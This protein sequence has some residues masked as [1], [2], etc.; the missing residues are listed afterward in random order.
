MEALNNNLYIGANSPRAFFVHLMLPHSPVLYDRHGYVGKPTSYHKNSEYAVTLMQEF[1]EKLKELSVYDHSA[2]FFLSD[3]GWGDPKGKYQLSEGNRF[4]SLLLIKG[5]HRK[6]E[7]ILSNKVVTVPEFRSVIEKISIN[8]GNPTNVGV[9]YPLTV[10][11]V[12]YLGSP[13]TDYKDKNYVIKE[14]I[15][16]GDFSKFPRWKNIA[17]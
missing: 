10:K 9:S 3:H 8:N 7:L 1:I 17:K 4:N 11:F 13:W 16:N 2:I 6:G 14:L 5:K 12:Q 15:F